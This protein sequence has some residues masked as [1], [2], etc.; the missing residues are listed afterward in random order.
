MSFL[1]VS[2]VSKNLDDLFLVKEIS[3]SQEQLQKI[4]IAG[5]TGSGKTTLLKMIG[6][7]LQPAS[8]TIFFDGQKV[9][10]PDEQLIQGH[11]QIAYLSQHFELRNHYRVSELLD[12]NN[13]LTANNAQLVYEVC[14]IDHLLHRWSHQLSGGE[15][16]RIALSALLLKAP[17]LLLLDE[18]YSNLDPIHKSVL[19][20]VIEDVGK[21]LQMSFIL[22]SHD[23]ADTLS[24]A[25]TILILNK[26][27]LLQEGSPQEI[28]Y[29]PGSEYA[30]SLFGNFNLLTPALAK[31]FSRTND[32]E[33]NQIGS[34]LRPEKFLLSKSG[35]GLKGIV[36]SVR[37]IGPYCE[38]E[39]MIAG[40]L[41]R[42]YS[43]QSYAVNDDVFVSVK[44]E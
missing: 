19:K 13:Q 2:A 31:I 44:L 36:K 27:E 32:I 16:Q 18:P 11:P 8:G 39:V 41:L 40:N 24:W 30:A 25:D 4:A 20:N 29:A 17:K 6:G 42:V 5:A 38:I 22:V 1:K 35:N 21:E 43:P 10:G 9:M 12:M 33:M 3:F 26:G 28:Y 34:F 7:L 23:G 37:F 15:R 14:R